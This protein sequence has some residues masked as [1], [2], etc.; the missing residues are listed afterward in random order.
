[1]STSEFRDAYSDDDNDVAIIP[2]PCNT[3]SGRSNT[4]ADV[5]ENDDEFHSPTS[6]EE[7][8]AYGRAASPDTLFYYFLIAPKKTQV[9]CH[10]FSMRD[11]A[12]I[13]HAR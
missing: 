11:D 5:N 3:T 8:I 10:R 7:T 2:A 13:G 9:P 4:V 12:R 1:M 6:S